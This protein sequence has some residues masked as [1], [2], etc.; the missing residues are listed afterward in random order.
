MATCSYPGC[1]ALAAR[2]TFDN[3]EI[4]SPDEWRAFEEFGPEKRGCFDHLPV[5][6]TYYLDGR[7]L[8]TEECLSEKVCPPQEQKLLPAPEVI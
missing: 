6:L 7:V 5:S 3:R 1:D 2:G 4:L 8:P